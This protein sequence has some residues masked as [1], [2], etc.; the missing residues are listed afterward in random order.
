MTVQVPAQHAADQGGVLLPH[1]LRGVLPPALGR[2]D[3]ARR[4]LD[5]LQVRLDEDMKIQDMET[6]QQEHEAPWIGITQRHC[7]L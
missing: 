2:L 1:H 3:R 4:A 7:S 6:R 5:R